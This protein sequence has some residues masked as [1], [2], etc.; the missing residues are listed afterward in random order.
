[1][2]E[3]Y[4]PLSVLPTAKPLRSACCGSS[5]KLHVIRPVFSVSFVV[6][7]VAVLLLSLQYYKQT[8]MAL[9]ASLSKV[10]TLQPQLLPF[11][12]NPTPTKIVFRHFF[13]PIGWWTRIFTI[14]HVVSSLFLLFLALFINYLFFGRLMVDFH[15]VYGTYGRPLIFH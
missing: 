14:S 2:N 3:S 12:S 9:R 10:R 4:T 7:G 8:T 6:A 13:D 5:K 1:L 15:R 11:S